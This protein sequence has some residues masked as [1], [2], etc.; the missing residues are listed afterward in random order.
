MTDQRLGLGVLDLRIVD[1]DQAAVLGLR[2]QSVLERQYA[3]LFRQVGRVRAD[4]R[5]EGTATAAELRHAGRAVT[6]TAGA[7][8]LVHL[9]AGAPDIGAAL[10]L[11]RS[12]LALVELPLHA[13]LDDVGAGLETEDRV[14]E[15]DGAGFLT[16]K[17]RD[18][19]FHL[20]RPPARPE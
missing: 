15:L 11:V 4:H 17:G 2:R 16:F 9:L 13:T 20:T 18:F 12:G 19:Q 1:H 6:G 10:R 7:L 8:L 14:R 5:T 3:D